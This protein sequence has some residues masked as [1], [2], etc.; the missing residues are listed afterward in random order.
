MTDRKLN[1]LIVDDTSLY[2]IVLTDVFKSFPQVRVVGTA[3]NGQI[4]LEKIKQLKPDLVSLDVEMPVMDGLETLRRIKSEY[5]DIEVVMVSSVTT[6]GARVTIE[7]LNSGAYDFITKPNKTNAAESIIQLQEEFKPKIEAL[8]TKCCKAKTVAENKRIVPQKKTVPVA[9]P[10]ALLN[11]LKPE[12]IAIGIST[13][14]PKALAEVIPKFS[15]DF[16]T[17]ILIVQHMPPLFT[18]ALAESLHAKSGLTVLEAENGIPIEKGHAY[19][20]PGGKQMKVI[21]T[22]AKK[23]IKITDDPPENFCKPSAD[24]LFRSVASVYKEKA[25]GV[26]MT[27]MGKDG[28]TG[29]RMMKR[30]GS[31][32][33]AQDAKSCVVFGM[34]AEAIKAGIVDEIVP[35]ENM[36]QR[37]MRCSTVKPVTSYSG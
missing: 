16:P 15:A 19:I 26:I 12:I 20:A 23:I 24:Y 2:R 25:L 21:K 31:R 36:A 34:P 13:G 32:I 9:A 5:P 7:A 30:Y 6:Q 10:A 11:S 33:F 35:L 14:G 1:V 4:A 29:L 3:A 28:V 37:I 8:F 22:D 27:G 18:K 17:P